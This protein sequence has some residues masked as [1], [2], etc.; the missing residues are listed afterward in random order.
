MRIQIAL[1]CIS[2]CFIASAAGEDNQLIH[3][4][5]ISRCLKTQVAFGVKLATDTNPYYLRGDFDGDGVPDYAVA[6]RGKKTKRRGILICGGMGRAFLLGADNPKIPP[7]SS[8]PDDI[9][10]ASTWFVYSRAETAELSKFPDSPHPF[11][12]VQGETIGMIFEDGI[13]LIYW[14]GK[15]YRWAQ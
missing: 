6:V 1:V 8:M 10:F 9:F 12:S 3:P 13:A 7:F 4:N 11:P 14:D 15:K 2:L 5:Q